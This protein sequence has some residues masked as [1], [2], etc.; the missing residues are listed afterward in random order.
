MSYSNVAVFERALSAIQT[1][2]RRFEQERAEWDVER[3]RLKAK[4]SAAEK[5]I[6]QLGS[7]YRVSQK[8]ITVLE[9]LLSEARAG[10]HGDESSSSRPSDEGETSVTIEQLV[11]VTQNTRQR[12]R[13]LLGRC[14]GEIEILLGNSGPRVS[15][16]PVP[17]PSIAENLRMSDNTSTLGPGVTLLKREAVVPNGIIESDV[18]EARHAKLGDWQRLVS[19]PPLYSNVID[20]AELVSFRPPPPP[21]RGER[22]DEDIEEEPQRP[23]SSATPQPVPAADPAPAAEPVPEDILPAPEDLAPEK[24][25]IRKIAERRRRI[26]QPPPA[27]TSPTLAP[28][29]GLARR[30]MSASHSDIE[31]ELAPLLADTA[32]HIEQAST[33]EVSRSWQPKKTFIGHMD[34]VRALQIRNGS[35][36]PQ[37]LSGSDDGM[38]I[39]WDVERSDRRKSRRQRTSGDVVPTTM[40]RGH[41]AAVTS[42]ACAEGHDFGYSG[43]LDSSIKV[44][45]L[46][47]S[48][49]D[50]VDACFPARAFA[51]HSDAVWDL[52]LSPNAGLLAS[53]A[54]DATCCLWSTDAGNDPLRATFSRDQQR[55]LLPTSACFVDGGSM[56][57]IA[58]VDGTVDLYD[59]AS[60]TLVAAS[61]GSE[62][63]ASRI[64]RVASA[65]HTLAVAY[66]S[67]EVRLVD[68][69]MRN[70]VSVQ[71]YALAAATAVDLCSEKS[72][73]VTGGSDGVVKWWDR[74]SLRTSLY[75]DNAHTP[76]ADEG[77]CD[78]RIL[79]A[80]LVVS[81]GGD[82]LARLYY[83]NEE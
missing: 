66:V 58:Y 63:S 32:S 12:S 13:E 61:M 30:R 28:V 76:K 25:P 56:L 80:T 42:V 6:E 70:N 48:I 54:A 2:W 27:A 45:A 78:V 22:S 35:E 72:L 36:G 20:S 47:E 60:E 37:L 38:V 40:Y 55:L 9:Q 39:L 52:A 82:G 50:D 14:L 1:E 17:S 7:L 21:L 75:E 67:G 18:G 64:T 62:M 68:T 71:A 57:A 73:L 43:S 5:R 77:V 11:T 34:T 23:E 74:R 41:L 51:G 31:R 4:L 15:P 83:Q 8:H 53:V 10:T 3:I 65:E 24:R 44:W 79:A 33:G 19:P 16:S 29:G 46:P 49:A 26:S 69:R 59:V 81:G